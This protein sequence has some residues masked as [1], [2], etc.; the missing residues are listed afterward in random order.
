MEQWL[1]R[2]RAVKHW[3]I[4]AAQGYDSSIKWL[5]A[6]FKHGFVEKDVLAAALRAHKAAA[7]ATKSP[8]R[9]RK[10]AEE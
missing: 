3:I 1:Y 6:A 4:S 2:E 5:M 9:Q 7:D 10:A 8:Q